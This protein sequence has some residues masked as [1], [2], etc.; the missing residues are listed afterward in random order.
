M[1]VNLT[2]G[3]VDYAYPELGNESWGENATD[4]ATAVTSQLNTLTVAG[5]I[6]LTSFSLLNNQ[7]SAAN[8]S[9]L[10][11]DPASVR[12]AIV[13][14]YI[15]RSTDSSNYA[16]FGQLFLVYNPIAA[17]WSEAR[18][19]AGSSGPTISGVQLSITSG[20]QVQYTSDSIAGANY[21]GSI[22]FRARV[23]K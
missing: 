11:F 22:K 14:Y 13:E 20:G 9:G 6:A 2:V 16:E 5:D 19:K 1:A 17:S 7:V 4:W 21:S 15:N 10:S 18:F 12:G 23:L 8:I 3:G